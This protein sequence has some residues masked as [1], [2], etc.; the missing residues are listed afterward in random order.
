[1]SRA[2]NAPITPPNQRNPLKKTLI[3]AIAVLLALAGCSSTT[4]EEAP[5]FAPPTQTV[6]PVEQAAEQPKPLGKVDGIDELRTAYVNA[7]FTCDVWDPT[8]APLYAAAQG[9]CDGQAVLSVFDSWDGVE[10][11]AGNLLYVSQEHDLGTTLVIGFNWI[12][13]TNN[14]DEVA[15]MLGGQVVGG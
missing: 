6:E 12:V 13:N 8:E 11:Q 3:P 4:D 2:P 10:E 15:E 5:A 7:G 9:G 14:A 1:M